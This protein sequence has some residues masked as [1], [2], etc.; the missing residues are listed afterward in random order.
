MVARGP[1]NH[2][3]A[4]VFS[5]ERHAF[6]ELQLQHAGMLRAQNEKAEQE[7]LRLSLENMELARKLADMT[8]HHDNLAAACANMNQAAASM[9]ELCPKPSNGI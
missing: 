6:E 7:V 2:D 1:Q 4:G 5:D 8:Q 9:M 3:S